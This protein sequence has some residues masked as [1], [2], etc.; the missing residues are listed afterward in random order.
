MNL[1]NEIKEYLSQEKILNKT[2]EKLQHAN[3]MAYEFDTDVELIEKAKLLEARYELLELKIKK[4]F[5][6]V[7]KVFKITPEYYVGCI[8]QYSGVVL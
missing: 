6:F 1:A 2:V 8:N 5:N 7:C 3:E 4:S